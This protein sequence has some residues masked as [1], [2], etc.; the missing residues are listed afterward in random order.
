MRDHR[1][2]VLFLL[3]GLQVMLKYNTDFIEIIIRQLFHSSY[4]KDSRVNF[5]LIKTSLL[6]W[7]LTSSSV[8]TH[9]FFFFDCE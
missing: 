4:L 3:C 6:L 8:D 7:S 2:M 5:F 1:L 9:A